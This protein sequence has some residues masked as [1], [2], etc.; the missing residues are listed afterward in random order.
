MAAVVRTT[1]TCWYAPI[2]TV[3]SS[4]QPPADSQFA[5]LVTPTP[6]PYIWNCHDRD[7][8]RP[9]RPFSQDTSTHFSLSSQND[10]LFFNCSEDNV[11]VE[12]RPIFCQLINS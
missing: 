12:P 1:D 10:Y 8:F 6:D 5:A 11:I 9:T 7:N 3:S 4:G 2:R